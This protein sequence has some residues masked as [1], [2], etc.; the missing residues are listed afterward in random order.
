M[1]FTI[2]STGIHVNKQSIVKVSCTA[3]EVAASRAKYSVE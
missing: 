3:E 2:R 1:L